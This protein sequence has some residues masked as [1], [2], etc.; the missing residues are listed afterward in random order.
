MY[1]VF[2]GAY[3]GTDQLCLIEYFGNHDFGWCKT[4]VMEPYVEGHKFV[5]SDDKKESGYSDKVTADA[6]A[7]EEADSSFEAMEVSKKQFWL[8]NYVAIHLVLSSV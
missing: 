3:V 5:L 6:Y 2:I 8:S 4:D 1:Y 7:I